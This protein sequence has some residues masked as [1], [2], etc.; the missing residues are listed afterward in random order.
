M[1]LLPSVHCYCKN[2]VISSL[3]NDNYR[4][5]HAFSISALL[6]SQDTDIEQRA[7]DRGPISIEE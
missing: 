4:L 6:S 2:N 5:M 7:L 3:E 1:Y